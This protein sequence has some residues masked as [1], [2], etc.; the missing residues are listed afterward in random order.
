[1]K[2]KIGVALD[3]G[4]S[5]FRAQAID[6]E[7][8]KVIST[9]ITLRHPLPGINI[10]DH[11][12]FAIEY[13]L[14]FAHEIFIDAVEKL[15][16]RLRGMDLKDVERIAVSGNP[17][18][19]SLFQGIEIRDLAWA[20]E[21]ALKIRNVTPPKRDATVK[22]AGEIGIQNVSPE[23][24]VLIPPCIKH[25]LGADA[26]AMMVKSGFLEKEIALVADYGTNAEIALKIGDRILTGSAA[27]GPAI[28]GQHI[29]RGM[30]A[31]PGAI[32][33]LTYS[34]SG[35]RCMVLDEEIYTRQGDIIDLA[36]GR[37]IEPGEMHGKA[38]GVTG[39][40]LIAALA[41]GMMNRLIKPPKIRTRDRR[42]NL[43]DGVYITEKDVEEAGKALGAFRAG[44]LTLAEEAGVNYKDIKT[45][46]MAGASGFYVDPLKAR[47]VGEIPSSAEEIYQVGNTSL[48]LAADLI[49]DPEYLDKLQNFANELRTQHVMFATSTIFQNVYTLELSYWT[50]GMSLEDYEKFLKVYGIRQDVRYSGGSPK[51]TKVVPR[52][53]ADLGKFGLTVVPDVGTTVEVEVEGCQECKECVKSCPENAIMSVGEG[54]VLISSSLCLGTACRRCVSACPLKILKFENARVYRRGE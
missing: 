21:R 10:M 17:T 53:I 38:K 4:T 39:T 7:S 15:L 31:A 36:T 18:Q 50:E 40:G 52:D 37:V 48:S 14:E 46:F 11:L 16:S 13:G 22:T 29:E 3:V 41:V 32:S 35:W 54:R 42:L 30:L 28:E 43:Q 24:E 6:L 23:V 9:A 49:R 25:E 5:G 27:A 12:T 34:I 20:G 44:F 1:M 8:G 19:L 33:D 45:V 51:V 47:I 2:Q 26:I